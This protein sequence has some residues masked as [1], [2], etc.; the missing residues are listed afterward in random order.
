[1]PAYTLVPLCMTILVF[2]VSTGIMM[3]HAAAA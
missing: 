1:M 3:Q 2:I